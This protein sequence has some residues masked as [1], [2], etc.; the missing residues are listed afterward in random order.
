M[1]AKKTGSLL[2]RLQAHRD[3]GYLSLHMPGHKENTRLAP[4]LNTLGAGLDI[5]ELPDFDDLHDPT[6]ILA[7]SMARAAALWGSEKSYYQVNGSS[8]A[9]LAAIRA[10]TRRGDR[11]LVA[12]NCHKSIYHAVELCGLN[13][14]FLLPPVEETFGL[15]GSISPEQVEEALEAYPDIKLIVYPSPTYDGVISDTAGIC[16]VAHA[17]SIPVLV[18]EAHGAHLGLTRHF[19]PNAAALGADLAVASLHKMLPSLTQTAI[20]HAG[21]Q[22]VNIPQVTRQTG[23]FQ[24]SSP[25]YLLMASMD[26]CTRLLESQRE[27]LF[28]QWVRRLAEFDRAAQGLRHLR[29]PFHGQEAGQTY[30]N[31]FAFDPAKI[32]ISTRRS[33]LSGVELMHILRQDYHIELEMALD[34]YAVAMTGLGTDDTMPARLANALLEIDRTCSPAEAVPPVEPVTELPPRVCSIEEAAMADSRLTSMEEAMGRTAAEYL[35]AYPPGIPLITPGE[36]V[37]PP[38]AETVR[39]LHRA[40]VK[41]V[42]TMGRP[43]VSIAVT[44]EG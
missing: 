5:T 8:G 19:P 15:S 18:D 28:T 40:G 3:E 21:G 26:S 42:G 12:R 16:R 2:E 34:H 6:E 14:V 30:P 41:L 33:S 23:I 39:R 10:A 35:W 31:I 27:E 36:V 32:V 11:V 25:S 29:L 43:P 44:E 13:P 24:S 7:E 4:Y 38:L 17:R 1:S 37:T 20:L 9:L 22:I